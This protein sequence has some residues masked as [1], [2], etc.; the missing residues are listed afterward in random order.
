[1][2]IILPNLFY[3]TIHFLQNTISGNDFPSLYFEYW[4]KGNKILIIFPFIIY[5]HYCTITHSVDISKVTLII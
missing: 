4:I 3:V 2:V 1:M 5:Q